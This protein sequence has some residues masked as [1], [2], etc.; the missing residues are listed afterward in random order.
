MDRQDKMFDIIVQNDGPLD[1]TPYAT[2]KEMRI[3]LINDVSK[4]EPRK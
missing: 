2:E 4:K 3:F 1:G